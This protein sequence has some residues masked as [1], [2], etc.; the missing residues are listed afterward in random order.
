MSFGLQWLVAWKNVN[1]FDFQSQFEKEQKYMAIK[2][3]SLHSNFMVIQTNKQVQFV[4]SFTATLPW[5]KPCI[6]LYS[7]PT[8]NL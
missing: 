3:F 6:F 2:A 4:A 5:H 7:R 8:A 1:Q